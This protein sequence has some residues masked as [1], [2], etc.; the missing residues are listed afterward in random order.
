MESKSEHHCEW[1]ENT[2]QV[3]ESESEHHGEWVSNRM[4]AFF[5]PL[6]SESEPQIKKIYFKT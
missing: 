2:L 5:T 4:K 6:E 1:D 3:L